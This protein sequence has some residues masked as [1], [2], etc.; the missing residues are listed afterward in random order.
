MH[1]KPRLTCVSR[2]RPLSLRLAPA[3]PPSA[4]RSNPLNPLDEWQLAVFYDVQTPQQIRDLTTLSDDD[5]HTTPSRVPVGTCWA[6]SI[7]AACARW[8]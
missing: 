8:Q 6:A 2:A 4:R 1:R 5:E 3:R 7:R